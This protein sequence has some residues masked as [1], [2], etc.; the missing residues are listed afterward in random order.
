MKKM[1]NRLALAAL[2]L[3]ASSALPALAQGWQSWYLDA[4]AGRGKLK[5][6][7]D[8]GLSNPSIGDEQTVWTGRLGYRFAPHIAVEAAYYDLGDYT[9][10]GNVF[11]APVRGNAKATAWGGAV[12]GTAPIGTRLEIYS[13]LGYSRATLKARVDVEGE[14]ASD[15]G[16]ENSLYY[17]LGGRYMFSPAVGFFFEW[18]K[19]D[20]VDV[21]SLMAGLQLRF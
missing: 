2:A 13:R 6:L 17:G 1:T 7:G 12:V 18:T 3:A 5:G 16:A 8:M 14:G 4:G 20:K 21:E 10:S 19:H 9:F 15:K 11:G